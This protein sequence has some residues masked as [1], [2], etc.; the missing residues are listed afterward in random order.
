M[1]R[2]HAVFHRQLLVV[3]KLR[4]KPLPPVPLVQMQ[5]RLGGIGVSCMAIL[6]PD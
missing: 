4:V 2:P 1:D 3:G 5:N 6:R